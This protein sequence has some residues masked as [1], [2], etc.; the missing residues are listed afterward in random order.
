MISIMKKKIK[1]TNNSRLLIVGLVVGALLLSIGGWYWTSHKKTD[2]ITRATE[3]AVKASNNSSSTDQTGG[4]TDNKTAAPSKSTA[5]TAAKSTTTSSSS[6]ASGS[7]SSNSTSTT[8]AQSVSWTTPTPLLDRQDSG[9]CL[10]TFSAAATL[11]QAIPQP[12]QKGNETV[13]L[14][15]TLEALSGPDTIGENPIY[16]GTK[17]SL[18]PVGTKAGKYTVSTESSTYIG[19]IIL[20]PGANYKISISADTQTGTSPKKWVSPAKTFTV[21]N[22]CA[23]F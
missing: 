10:Y 8:P 14:M 12:S 1:I 13:W 19:D 2:A 4:N 11:S 17:P 21:P 16:I 23:A 22:D 15:A 6:G 20:Y 7:G 9:E 5:P 18:L 3:E